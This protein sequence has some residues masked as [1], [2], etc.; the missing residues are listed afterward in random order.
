[1]K[2]MKGQSTYWMKK[3]KDHCFLLALAICC[4]FPL[5]SSCSTEESTTV[6]FVA[7]YERHTP[8]T[9]YS[10]PFVEAILDYQQENG[11]LGRVRPITKEGSHLTDADF[12][13]MAKQAGKQILS[14]MTAHDYNQVIKDA[15]L[16]LSEPLNLSITYQ[17][18][19]A[20]LDGNLAVT[21]GRIQLNIELQ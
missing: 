2:T 10:L 7:A 1:M 19:A 4:L 17:I 5:L 12:D 11:L 3:V 13:E 6:N 18:G 16:S 9:T 15:G 14:E 20:G 8:L 21:Y